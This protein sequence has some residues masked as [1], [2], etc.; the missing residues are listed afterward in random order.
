MMTRHSSLKRRTRLRPISTKRAKASRI[1]LTARS[2]FLGSH[3]VC[4]RCDGRR[5]TDIHHTAGRSGSNY[6][7]QTTWLALCR[8]CHDWIHQHP[9]QARAK[10][11]LK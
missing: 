8:Q 5:S 6:Q 9:S 1:Y 4:Q 7:D 2:R 10:N 11:L 3:P